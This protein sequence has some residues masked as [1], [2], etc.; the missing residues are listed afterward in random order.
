[1]LKKN[2]LGH[3]LPTL[4]GRGYVLGRVSGRAAVLIDALLIISNLFR[5]DIRS[6]HLLVRVCVCVRARACYGSL[7]QVLFRQKLRPA[8]AAPRCKTIFRAQ[9]SRASARE[10][11]QKGQKGQKEVN[12]SDV[13]KTRKVHTAHLHR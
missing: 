10:E 4:W 6:S 3:N 13:F 12:K 11:G 2:F 9:S 8:G 1:M 5:T 7:G